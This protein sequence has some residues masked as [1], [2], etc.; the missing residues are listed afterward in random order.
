MIEWERKIENGDGYEAGDGERSMRRCSEARSSGRRSRQRRP[1][2]G[3]RKLSCPREIESSQHLHWGPTLAETSIDWLRKIPRG[4]LRMSRGTAGPGPRAGAIPSTYTCCCASAYS[5]KIQSS[6]KRRLSSSWHCSTHCFFLLFFFS[7]PKLLAR[8]RFSSRY[9]TIDRS[10]ARKP[11]CR[12]QCRAQLSKLTADGGGGAPGYLRTSIDARKQH[13]NKQQ[14]TSQ[15]QQ[16]KNINCTGRPFNPAPNYWLQL[17]L[18]GAF[19]M[20]LP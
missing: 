4:S 3:P 1:M 14:E 16:Q 15:N 6:H 12:A 2:Q 17:Q 5:Q 11:N 13:R 18:N 10:M 19:I 9:E 7:S 20:F 8:P